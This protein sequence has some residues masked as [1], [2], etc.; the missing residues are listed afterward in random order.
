MAPGGLGHRTRAHNPFH[1][2]ITKSGILRMFS[3]QKRMQDSKTLL[4]L[5]RPRSGGAIVYGLLVAALLG[6]PPAPAQGVSVGLAGGWYPNKDF[7]EHTIFLD[8]RFPPF[9]VRSDAGGYVAGATM[10]LHLTRDL[11]IGVDAL[12][13]PLHYEEAATFR[14]KPD[15][16]REVIGYAPATVVTWQFPVLMRYKFRSRRVNP[17]VEG[18]PSF[19]TAGNLNSSNPSHVGVSAG[20]GVEF[21]WGRFA[22]TPSARYTRWAKEQRGSVQARLDQVEFLVRASWKIWGK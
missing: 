19:R 12:Y 13:K 4:R 9:I 5:P 8:P 1:L 21:R 7:I 11:S 18:G 14:R 3:A 20:A 6:T 10:E 15:G 17:F 16:S 2:V 22:L